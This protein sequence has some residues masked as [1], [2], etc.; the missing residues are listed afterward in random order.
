MTV[1]RQGD[2]AGWGEVEIETQQDGSMLY[3]AKVC[4]GGADDDGEFQ[5]VLDGPAV[6]E[7]VY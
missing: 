1:F 2:F 3:Y 4:V 5:V 6:G 7:K